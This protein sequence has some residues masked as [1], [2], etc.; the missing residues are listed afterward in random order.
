MSIPLPIRE[1]PVFSVRESAE[2]RRVIGSVSCSTGVEQT[3]LSSEIHKT[4]RPDTVDMHER[5]V[6]RVICTFRE[7]LDENISLKEM[8]A[9]AYM[10]RYHFNRTFRQITGLPPCRFLTKLR[11]EAATR[12][13]LDTDN[14]V[15]EICLDV[16]YTSLGT[17]VRRFSHLLGVSPMRLRT[18]RRSTSESLLKR[19]EKECSSAAAQPPPSVSGRV[20]APSSFSGPVFIGLFPT[21]IPEGT[22]LACAINMQPGPYLMSPVPNGRYYV[23]ALGL[24]CPDSLDDFFR[25]EAA[26]RGGGQL[27]KVN[28]NAVECEEICLREAALTDPPVLLNLPILLNKND[29]VRIVA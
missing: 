3:M 13:L 12:M 26:L 4:K 5:A 25:Y 23:F 7:R 28:N 1:S 19:L 6:Q 16:G 29:G 20:Q 11:V 22:P 15:T 9:V 18:L 17:F 2:A 8:A 24:P 10:S 21:P 14:S 27:I